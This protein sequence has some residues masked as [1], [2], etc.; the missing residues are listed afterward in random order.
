MSTLS[1]QWERQMAKW[2]RFSLEF[3]RQAVEKM[4]TS[5]NVL[6]LSRELELDRKS[7][8]MWRC[9][10]EGRPEKRR[11]DYSSKS[12]PNT[13]EKCLR[14]ENKELKEALGEKAAQ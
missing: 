5:D 2:R 9:Q 11:A 10:F 4:K 1:I 12:A 14:R 6:E 13:A 7:L 3:K 8:Y